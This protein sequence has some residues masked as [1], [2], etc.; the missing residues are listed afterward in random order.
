V[1]EV[2]ERPYD[3]KR[4]VVC[5]DEKSKQLLKESRAPITATPHQPIRAD[6]EYERNGTCNLLLPLSQ[7]GASGLFV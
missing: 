7:R 3:Q 5:I 6:Y 2:Y 4:P 1:L